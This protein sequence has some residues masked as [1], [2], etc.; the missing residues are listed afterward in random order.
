MKT[1][2]LC[3]TKVFLLVTELTA[4]QIPAF[5]P[6]AASNRLASTSQD[7]HRL[8]SVHRA[9]TSELLYQQV[10][11]PTIYMFTAT[12][13][14]TDNLPRSTFHKSAFTPLAFAPTSF[15]TKQLLHRPAFTPTSLH[16]ERITPQG[17]RTCIWAPKV[18]RRNMLK[19]VK[20]FE[21]N[22]S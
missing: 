13:F 19:D 4:P 2:K 1:A 6:G 20:H 8:A 15:C 17:P 10:F 18:G 11:P 14:C 21:E 5:T 22:E 9:F 7:L 16:H 12:T 3:N